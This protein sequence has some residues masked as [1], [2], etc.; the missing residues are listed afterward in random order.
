MRTLADRDPGTP[1]L[2]VLMPC[3]DEARTVASCVRKA[4][5]VCKLAG[6]DAEPDQ[7]PAQDRDVRSALFEPAAVCVQ[8]REQDVRVETDA[9]A[10]RQQPGSESC[11]ELETADEALDPRA[12]ADAV[13]NE[14]RLRENSEERHLHSEESKR[15]AEQCEMRLQDVSEQLHAREGDDDSERQSEEPRDRPGNDE[16]PCRAEEQHEP[17]M[18]PPIT[19]GAQVRT[20]SAAIGPQAGRHLADANSLLRRPDDHFAG[21]LHA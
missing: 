7:R 2:T 14:E 6:I 12:P 8:P 10:E 16:Q 17:K 1:E 20:P 9:G 19:P 5:E 15:A 3:L 21:E 11:F 4:I 13:E 18:A